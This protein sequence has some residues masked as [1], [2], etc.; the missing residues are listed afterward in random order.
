MKKIAL[1]VAMSIYALAADMNVN[2][3]VTGM[4]CPSC[5]KNVKA[6]ASSI[7]GVKDVKVYLKDGR[8]DVTCDSSVKAQNIA[9]AIKKEGYGAEVIK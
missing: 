3:K 6:A 5:A 8:A 1:V 2:L 9:E 4:T 7:N